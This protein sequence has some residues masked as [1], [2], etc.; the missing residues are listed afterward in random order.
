MRAG[1]ERHDELDLVR[2]PHGREIRVGRHRRVEGEQP[3]VDER[4]A[5]APAGGGDA[6][7]LEVRGGGS[8]RTGDV[9]QREVVA[10]V[11]AGALRAEEERLAPLDLVGRDEEVGRGLRQP[12]AVEVA[13]ERGGQA[14]VV[15][16]LVGEAAD[17]GDLPQQGAVEDLGPL[18]FVETDEVGRAERRAVAIAGSREAA[19]EDAAGR[20]AGDQVE[21]LGRPPARPALEVREHDRGDQPADPTAVDRE[22]PHEG[23][24]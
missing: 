16:A 19:G 11:L 17:R 3:A 8:G 13:R 18:T 2:A 14:T 21:Q 10:G 4:V 1:A 7:G 9:D 12:G 5:V 20:R 15:V 24:P 6:H 23:R 22:D